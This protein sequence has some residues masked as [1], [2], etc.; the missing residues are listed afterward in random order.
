MVSWG[1]LRFY[2]SRD[3]SSAMKLFLLVAIKRIKEMVK[4]SVVLSLE[5]G[6]K[7]LL[8]GHLTAAWLYYVP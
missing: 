1:A 8:F 4:I 3:D 7:F 5:N 2:Q 6:R